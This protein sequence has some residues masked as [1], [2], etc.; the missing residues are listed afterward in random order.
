MFLTC[1]LGK[2]TFKD[3]KTIFKTRTIAIAGVFYTA[4]E[5]LIIYS[6]INIMPVSFVSLFMR[7]AIPVIMIISAIRYKEQSIRNQL[8]L[9]FVSFALALPLILIK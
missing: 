6:M 8:I 2:V 4:S 1:F 9:G 3:I 5:F 7:L